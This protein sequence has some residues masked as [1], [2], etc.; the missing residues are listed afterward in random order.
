[1]ATPASPN[2]ISLNN[3]NTELGLSA[4]AG[5]TMNDTA[6]RSLASKPTNTSQISMSD[7]RGKSRAW[8]GTKSSG[9]LRQPANKISTCDAVELSGD[10]N[11]MAASFTDPS[12]ASN[13]G[14]LIYTRTSNSWALQA[15]LLPTP[16]SVGGFGF[17]I[18]LSNNGDYCVVGSPYVDTM[19]QS[20]SGSA[21]SGQSYSYT[22]SVALGAV[23]V[24][25][26]SG[27]TWTQQAK[28]RPTNYIWNT[29]GPTWFEFGKSVD[30]NSDGTIIAFGSPGDN[31]SKN[32]YS[33][34]NQVHG[35]YGAIYIYSRSGTTWTQ[36]QKISGNIFANGPPLGS[37]IAMTPDASTIVSSSGT[38]TNLQ[39]APWAQGAQ[40]QIFNRIGST[41]SLKQT[42]GPDSSD[43]PTYNQYSFG[44]HDFGALAISSNGQ[45]IAVG[46]PTYSS[47]F[48]PGTETPTNRGRTKI[49]T[50]NGSTW[51]LQS[52]LT[53]N[54]NIAGEGNSV[55][56]SSNGD[57]LLVGASIYGANYSW[58][59]EPGYSTVIE[60]EGAAFLYTRT[61]T[62][63]GTPTRIDPPVGSVPSTTSGVDQYFD[64]GGAG[65]AITLGYS[66]AI[67]PD[68][69]ITAFAL[70]TEG[71]RGSAWTLM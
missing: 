28:I 65:S 25:V 35:H 24:F 67:T 34:L 50:Y 32:P 64:Y 57:K 13:I 20:G 47:S 54:I 41:Y 4:T 6:V 12:T 15:T 16:N 26:R 69:I 56:L 33:Y 1:M 9:L 43:I 7:L 37:Y 60:A 23:Y 5:I 14:V 42:I 44:Q 18:A 8:S 17:S 39:S 52:Y 71:D 62:A 31:N 51:N 40:L 55:S 58:F 49:Y 70:R 53:Q 29:F 3:V 30:I 63:W 10:G 61:G 66:V 46:M 68:A 22:Q 2:S 21:G 11:T 48:L 38:I 36:S 27:T 59:T 19:T 45:T